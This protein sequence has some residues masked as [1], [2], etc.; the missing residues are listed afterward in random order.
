LR[1]GEGSS[2]AHIFARL[3]RP[4]APAILDALQR[5]GVVEQD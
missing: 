5:D 1:L 4:A 2:V 3:D